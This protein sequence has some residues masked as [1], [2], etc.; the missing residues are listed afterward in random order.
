MSLAGVRGCR[1]SRK[2]SSPRPVRPHSTARSCR[3]RAQ[4]P[5]IHEARRL[6]CG[7]L[8]HCKVTTPWPTKSRRL[9]RLEDWLVD[10]QVLISSALYKLTRQNLMGLI[11]S[12]T[13]TTVAL[14]LGAAGLFAALI[15]LVNAS[16]TAQSRSD[17]KQHLN[18]IHKI[19]ANT[20]LTVLRI[21]QAILS[22]MSTTVINQ[23]FE[24]IQWA[25]ASD[26]RGISYTSFLAISPITGPWGMFLLVVTP[27][28][29]INLSSKLWVIL[30]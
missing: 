28:T 3:R 7:P 23:S 25:R 2:P 16:F 5:R 26:R 19:D 13:W 20:M 30:R 24:L 18:G 1:G 15:V 10:K 8:Y 11:S 17:E 12:A 6:R 9:T 21:I 14:S 27:L 22:T 29:R 4:C